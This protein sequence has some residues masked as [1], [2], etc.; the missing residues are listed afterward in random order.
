MASRSGDADRSAVAAPSFASVRSG[1][2]GRSPAPGCSCPRLAR[3]ARCSLVFRIAPKRR[4]TRDPWLP[5]ILRGI[6]YFGSLRLSCRSLS[7]APSIGAARWCSSGRSGISGG[8]LASAVSTRAD[9]TA[10]SCCTA[11]SPPY[12]WS[13]PHTRLPHDPW[14]SRHTRVPHQ[15]GGLLVF[16]SLALRDSL[17]KLG[18][19]IFLGSLLSAGMLLFH[20]SLM[21]SG[22]PC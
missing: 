21:F 13:S 1:W 18:A 5:L 6:N 22:T 15:H 20:G 7:A 14:S 2:R 19:L 11:P 12:S 9:D 10:H 8:S 17:Y 4:G 3:L 16:G